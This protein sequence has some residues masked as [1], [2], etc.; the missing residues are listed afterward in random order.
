MNDNIKKT[1]K[2]TNLY[3]KLTY[4]DD[5]SSSI[6]VFVIIT[7]VVILICV[8]CYVMIRSESIK[9]DW[10]NQR[11]K[12]NIIPFAGFINKPDNMSATEYT[13]ENFRYCN[14]VNLD[15]VSNAAVSPYTEII[16]NLTNL[17][18]DFTQSMNSVRDISSTIRNNMAGTTNVVYE[19]IESIIT[20]IK[21]LLQ[22]M[23][24]ELTAV[25]LWNAQTIKSS[26]SQWPEL[27]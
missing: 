20:P 27:E 15:K 9:R 24:R 7:L 21:P 22:K 2:I 3:K 14:Q 12:P 1:E 11:C 25:P 6:L 26:D 10:I 13:S 18:G 16:A 5:Y 4:I 17:T 8:Y 23:V 19:K